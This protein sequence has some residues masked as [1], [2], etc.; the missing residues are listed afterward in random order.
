MRRGVVISGLLGCVLFLAAAHGV[1]AATLDVMPSDTGSSATSGHRRNMLAKIEVTNA[2]LKLA[3]T[4]MD[5]KFFQVCALN[6][7]NPA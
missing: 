5:A 2:A 7:A 1:S 3:T 4:I 6:G